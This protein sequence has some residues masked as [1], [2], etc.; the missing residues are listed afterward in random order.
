MAA[1]LRSERRDPKAWVAHRLAGAW[2]ADRA[3]DRSGQG[4]RHHAEEGHRDHISGPVEVW[5]RR[6]SAADSRH[7]PEF[8][9][10]PLTLARSDRAARSLAQKKTHR[11]GGRGGS[12]PGSLSGVPAGSRWCRPFHRHE[13]EAAGE[14]RDQ[15]AGEAFQ[16]HGDLRRA[17]DQRRFPPEVWPYCWVATFCRLALPAVAELIGQPR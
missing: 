17:S 15:G 7:A 3:S 14:G 8:V 1:R 2:V 6:T 11:D 9:Y 5:F 4:C 16:R 10:E 13:D 12:K